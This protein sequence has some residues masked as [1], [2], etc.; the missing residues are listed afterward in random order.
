L[1]L[2]NGYI[3]GSLGKIASGVKEKFKESAF[4]GFLC[5]DSAVNDAIDE[6]M[7]PNAPE[8]LRKKL[9]KGKKKPKE[10][11]LAGRKTL[12]RAQERVGA[13][14]AADLKKGFG[15]VFGGAV[16]H[17][18]IIALLD[19]FWKMLC[20]M[21]ASLVGALMLLTSISSFAVSLI[22]HIIKVSTQADTVSLFVSI[23]TFVVAVFLIST[24]TKSIYDLFTQSLF[25]SEFMKNVMGMRVVEEKKS[26]NTEKIATSS[27]RTFVVILFCLIICVLSLWVGLERIIA[28]CVIF[29]LIVAIVK[30]PESGIMM[31]L[32]SFPWFTSLENGNLILGGISLLIIIS[33]IFKISVGKRVYTLRFVDATVGVFLLVYLFAG[34]FGVGAADEI[35]KTLS[36][37]AIAALYFPISGLIRSSEWIDRC[38][39]AYTTGTMIVSFV[40]ITQLVVRNINCGEMVFGVTSAFTNNHSLCAYL[41]VGI[42]IGIFNVYEKD[43]GRSGISYKISIALNLACFILA[44]SK[45]AYLA[46]FAAFLIYLLIQ[47]PKVVAFGAF[48]TPFLISIWIMMPDMIKNTASLLLESTDVE[49][50]SK[51]YIWKYALGSAKDHLLFGIGTQDASVRAIF[52]NSFGVLPSSLQFY[53]LYISIAVQVGIV[54]LLVFGVFSVSALQ[55]G[56]FVVASAAKGTYFKNLSAA[57]TTAFIALLVFGMGNSLWHDACLLMLFF[58]AVAMLRCIR[59]VYVRETRVNEESEPLDIDLDVQRKIKKE[60]KILIF[61]VQNL[62]KAV[63]K[64]KNKPKKALKQIDAE[65]FDESDLPKEA[66]DVSDAVLIEEVDLCEEESTWQRK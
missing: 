11:T 49:L 64:L 43:D 4:W 3:L 62:A 44:G 27:P 17:S 14:D 32:I 58:F 47:K 36:L 55:R 33:W 10:K 18:K 26:E 50:K 53:N 56:F 24:G 41:L 52:D 63:K 5:G 30:M 40:G 2:S 39:R 45:T 25:G 19:R 6:S 21:Q 48:L 22:K 23:L 31:L 9:S 12:E 15:Y 34:I 66:D 1:R 54:G 38:T 37:V 61:I 13:V 8:Y 65:F 29:A 28:S 7:I 35:L 20:N 60:S 46:L 16:R 42:F 51:L 57:S 59:E